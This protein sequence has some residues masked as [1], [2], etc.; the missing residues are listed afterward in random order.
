MDILDR[1]ISDLE[2]HERYEQACE[3]PPLTTQQRIDWINRRMAALGH[4]P[5]QGIVAGD[6][7]YYPRAGYPE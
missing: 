5:R 3:E 6:G 1:A 4:D 2:K 7:C